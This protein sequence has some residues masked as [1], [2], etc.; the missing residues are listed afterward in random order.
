M[1]NNQRN[2]VSAKPVIALA[3]AITSGARTPQTLIAPQMRT[4]SAKTPPS[5]RLDDT[6][7]DIGMSC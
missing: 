2:V 1:R 5:L 7:L 4:K 3:P 6:A